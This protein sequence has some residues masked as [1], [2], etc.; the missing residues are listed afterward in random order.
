MADGTQKLIEDLVVGDVI[1]SLSIGGLDT[2]DENNWI[3]YSSDSFE[4]TK[5][6]AT[7][8]GLKHGSY[9]QYYVINFILGITYEHPVFIKRNGQ[10]MFS[11]VKDLTRG[12]LLFNHSEEFI[13]IETIQI[14]NEYMPTVS[15]DI[16]EDDVYF[17]SGILVHNIEQTK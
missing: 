1:C 3:T 13:P 5:S 11:Q 4:Y 14:I 16:E 8:V 7:I 6:E 17:G 2:T 10:Y 12:D 15:I 9:R